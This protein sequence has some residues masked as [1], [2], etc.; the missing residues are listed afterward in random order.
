MRETA[1]RRL[2]ADALGVLRQLEDVWYGK[3]MLSW[4]SS[5]VSKTATCT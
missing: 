5:A 1:Q 3:T 2:A 4:S